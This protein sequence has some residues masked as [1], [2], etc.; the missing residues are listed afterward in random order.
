[1]PRRPRNSKGKKAVVPDDITTPKIPHYLGPPSLENRHVAWRFSNADHDGPFRC[2]S[3]SHEEFT[4]LWERLRAFERM[5]VA[6]LR[7]AQSYHSTPTANLAK[8]AK[9]RLEQLRL[10]DID[11]LYSF[12][13]TQTCRLW[14][15]KHENIM[16]VLWWD[17]SHEV[18]IVNKKHT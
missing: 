3:L 11:T 6:Q 12:R 15:I 1:M 5:N 13:I 9:D 10:D 14:C 18:Y 8:N 17:K 16:S 2:D 7:N 4:S